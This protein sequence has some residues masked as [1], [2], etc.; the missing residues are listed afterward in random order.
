MDRKLDELLFAL[1]QNMTI[2][3]SGEKLARDLDVSHS[4]L[5]R[6]VEK[7][8]SAGVEIRGELFTGYRLIRLPDVLL[9][10]LIRPRLRSQTLGKNLFHFFSVDSTNAFASRLLNHGR[11][12]ADGTVIIAE[13]Q[14]AG[15]GRRGRSWYSEQENGLYFSLVLHPRI[16]PAFAPL[17][18]L[19]TAV[20]IHNAVERSTGLQ[21]DIKWPNDLLINGRK[22]CGILAEMRAEFDRVNSL[23]IGV[24]LNVN[25]AEL[26]ADIAESATSLR[27]A[28]GRTHSRIEIMVEILEEFENLLAR[29]E[30]SGP[31]TIIDLWTRYSSFANGRRLGIHDGFRTIEGTTRGLNAFGALRLETW[32]GKIE[33]IY[34]GDVVSLQ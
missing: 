21:V 28:S 16:P 25:H 26:P 19:G 1:M 31:G 10:Q 32:D 6:W 30:K 15:K 20:A 27:M 17:F 34:S 7:L 24:G 33:E 29:F 14:T 13:S 4:T 22:F 23:I 2:A 8:R 5:V 9:P 12:V 18:T 3:V 11:N